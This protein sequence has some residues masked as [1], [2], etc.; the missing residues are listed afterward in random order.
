MDF[1]CKYL[2]GLL[3]TGWYGGANWIDLTK[4]REPQTLVKREINIRFP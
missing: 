3:G 2:I 4:D 1:V